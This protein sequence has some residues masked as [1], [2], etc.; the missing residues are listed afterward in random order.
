MP[1]GKRVWILMSGGLVEEEEGCLEWYCAL[2]MATS[3][4]RVSERDFM[5]ALAGV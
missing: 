5:A 1:M 2:C 4:T 3:W